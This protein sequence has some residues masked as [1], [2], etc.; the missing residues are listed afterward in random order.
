MNLRA[1][2]GLITIISACSLSACGESTS[3]SQSSSAERAAAAPTQA[4]E[5]T[6][7][8]RLAAFF[9]EVFERQLAQSPQFQSQLGI[10]GDDYGRLDDYSD[11][12]AKMQNEQRAADLRRLREE[13]DFDA[14]SDSSKVSYL[15]FEYSA[16]QDLKDFPWRRHQFLVNQMRDI[17]GNLATFM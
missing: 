7:D 13:F 4:T 14:L 8:A 15:L 16:E 10:R 3:N 17:S 2:I 9:E 12:F 6:E 5:Q 11:A 1:T